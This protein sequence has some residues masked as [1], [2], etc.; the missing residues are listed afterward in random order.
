MIYVQI[1]SSMQFS[2]SRLME[3]LSQL[4]KTR[5]GMQEQAP[6]PL[7]RLMSL[8]PAPWPLPS[9]APAVQVSLTSLLLELSSPRQMGQQW[10]QGKSKWLLEAFSGSKQTIYTNTFCKI[11][12]D[13]EAIFQLLILSLLLLLLK[14]DN[15]AT[16]RELTVGMLFQDYCPLETSCL[17]KVPTFN[18]TNA[19]LLRG[20]RAPSKKGRLPS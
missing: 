10:W 2:S 6:L 9:C 20:C 12:I 4:F 18:S 8:W 15:I 1:D 17:A 3:R 19:A 13:A 16:H 11:P 5:I 14:Y 7:K